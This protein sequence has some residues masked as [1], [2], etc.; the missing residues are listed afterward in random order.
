MVI[1]MLLDMSHMTTDNMMQPRN[2]IFINNI[3]PNEFEIE[4]Q[5]FKIK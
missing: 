5:S 2:Y 3:V 1:L 4:N